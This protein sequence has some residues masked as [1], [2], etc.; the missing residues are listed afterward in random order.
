VRTTGVP[1]TG[2]PTAGAPTARAAQLASPSAAVSTA[3]GGVAGSSSAVGL[4]AATQAQGETPAT[5]EATGAPGASAASS[6]AVVVA[7]SAQTAQAAQGRPGAVAAARGEGGLSGLS[8]APGAGNAHAGAEN[9]AGAGARGFASSAYDAR[10]ASPAAA[11]ESAA[12]A[13]P[14]ALQGALAQTSYVTTGLEASPVYGASAAAQAGAPPAVTGAAPTLATGVAMQ[15]MIDAIRAS[16]EIAA[17]QGLTQARITLQP[18]DLGHISVRLSQTSAGLLARVSAETP[19]A[20][21]A[22]TA[23]RAELH[24][25]LSSL[26]VSLLRLDISSFGQS[27]AGEQDGHFAGESG[28]SNASRAPGSSE[29]VEALD[30]AGEADGAAPRA[31][32]AGGELVDVLA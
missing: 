9:D 20:A 6:P 32:I 5:P 7:Q 14:G 3:P 24:Q 8:P 26:G 4:S 31:S 29:E 18:E 16:V 30:T 27:Q 12:T 23:G 11:S 28:A 19:A 17:R 13:Q 22:L 25:S 15:D 1:T 10:G 2:A 21:Q